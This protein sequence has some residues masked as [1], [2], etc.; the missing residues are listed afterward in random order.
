MINSKK[1]F[2]LAQQQGIQSLELFTKRTARL[3]VIS[4]RNEVENMT[5]N[6]VVFIPPA[7]DPG[8]PPISINIVVIAIPTSVMDN[9]ST[10]LNPAV[11]G[12][13]DWNMELQ[14]RSASGASV[15]SKKKK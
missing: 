2:Q 13:T 11:L 4:Y 10:V 7:V 14:N 15:N 9:W 12:V 1:I 5:A 8:D 6:V 3:S